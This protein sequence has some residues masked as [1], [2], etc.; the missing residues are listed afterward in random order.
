MFVRYELSGAAAALRELQHARIEK[1]HKGPGPRQIKYRLDI[2]ILAM[3][4]IQPIP[5]RQGIEVR[6][7][8]FFLQE[9]IRVVEERSMDVRE[10]RHI[11]VSRER[12]HA[13]RRRYALHLAIHPDP[14]VTRQC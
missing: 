1:A 2:A 5:L 9:H 7:T 3:F 12:Q 13:L 6:A 4:E 10:P 8:R 14:P 11:S